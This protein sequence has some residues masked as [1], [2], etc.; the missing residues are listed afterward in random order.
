MSGPAGLTVDAAGALAWTPSEAQGPGAYPVEVSV[1]DGDLADTDTF[2]ITVAEVN[3]PPVID[4]I[5]DVTLGIAEALDADADATD[6]DLPANGLAFSLVTAPAGATIDPASGAIAWAGGVPGSHPFTVRVTDDGSPALSAE[7]SFTVTVTEAP[8]GPPVLDDQADATIDEQAP[9]G[10]TLTGSDPD[11]DA[12]TFALVSGPAGLT[13]DAAGAVAW[14]DRPRPRARGAYPVEVSVSDGDLA[15]TDTFT[16]T[17]AEVNRPPVIDPI[18]DVTLGIAEALDADADA[19]DPDLPANG[20]AFSLVTAPAGATI[21]PASGA[22]AWAGGVPGSH[23][24]TVRVTDDGSPALS[25]E[26]SFT[27][28]VTEAP[29]GPPVLDD[30]ADATIDEQAPYGRTLTGSD[31]DGDALAVRP[32]VGPRGHVTV[33]ARRGGS[34]WTPTEAQ[35]PGALPG[36][37]SA[38]PTTAPS[39]RRGRRPSPSRCARWTGHPALDAHRGRHPRSRRGARRRCRRIQSGPARQR[40]RLQ[41]HHV[42]AGATIDPATGAIAWPGGAAGGYPFT[43]RVTDDGSPALFAETSFTVTVSEAPTE[44]HPPV[45]EQKPDATIDEQ[46]AF[47]RYPYPPPIHGDALSRFSVVSVP[48]A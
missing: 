45:L 47:V 21:D 38:R 31:P 3:R 30:Q 14:D 7:T 32:R 39:P 40:P 25:R 17:V 28:T 36:R 19:T 11:G 24:F 13:V 26:T 37:R 5:A 2:T 10:R 4:P 27:V 8:N 15:D 48:T 44:N 1:S 43:V 6:P 34:R 20:L 35:G 42:P 33:D 12:L 16:I 23:P 29:N 46:T 18:A 41:P 22:I 9:Y